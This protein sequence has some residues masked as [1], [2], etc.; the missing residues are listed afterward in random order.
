MRKALIVL[1]AAA[2]SGVAMPS[3][4]EARDGCGKGWHRNAYGYCRP[5]SY[6]QRDYDYYW[7]SGRPAY[8]QWPRYEIYGSFP[9]YR[10]GDPYAWDRRHRGDDWDW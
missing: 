5:N 7:Y 9:R 10:G 2:A 8:R 3:A 6:Y 1:I 4:A